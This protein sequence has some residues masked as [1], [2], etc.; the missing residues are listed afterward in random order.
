METLPAHE[1]RQLLREIREA[2]APRIPER[3]LG[4]TYRLPEPIEIPLS[5]IAA[6]GTAATAIEVRPVAGSSLSLILGKSHAAARVEV[7]L[8]VPASSER[9]WFPMAPGGRVKLPGGARFSGFR[10]R[11]Q[12]GAPADADKLA[13]FAVDVDQ[14]G[15]HVEV[16]RFAQVSNGGALEQLLKVLLVSGAEAHLE[17]AQGSAAD[18]AALAVA[19]WTGAAYARLGAS[20]AGRA[21]VNLI[22]GQD[23]VA[24][25]AGVVGADVLRVALATDDPVRDVGDAGA[26]TLRVVGATTPTSTSTQAT[27]GVA[28]GD[29]AAANAARKALVL[30]NGSST[31]GDGVWVRCGADATNT[32]YLLGPGETLTL[33]DRRRVSVLRQGANDVTVYVYEESHA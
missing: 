1:L 10:V 26:A 27:A 6:A 29:A 5:E 21:L 25:G 15:Q 14:D 4:G 22:A 31:A 32:A 3:L 24:G 13:V 11:L 30:K 20:A 18:R 17:G 9:A 7:C 33:T 28:A 16:G 2:I 12:S 19:G 8:D 23:G